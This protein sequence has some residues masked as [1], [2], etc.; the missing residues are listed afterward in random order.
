MARA[1][2]RNEKTWAELRALFV[3]GPE[4]PWERLAADMQAAIDREVRKRQPDDV[5]GSLVTSKED[6]P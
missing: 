4:D 6:E 5:P 3:E 1:G 2:V